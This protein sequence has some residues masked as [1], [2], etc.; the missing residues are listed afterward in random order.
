M[1]NHLLLM[2]LGCLSVALVS[3]T[4]AIAGKGKKGDTGDVKSADA[5]KG[6]VKQADAK[7]CEKEKAKLEALTL[8]G[9]LA[10]EEVE[11][12]TKDGGTIS[13]TV[14]YV[15]T[16]EEK[17]MVPAPRSK[18]KGEEP[19]IKLADFAGAKVTIIARGYKSKGKDG[20]ERTHVHQITDIRR[21]AAET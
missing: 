13:M 15:Q 1:K 18:K 21:I 7:K 3:V 10:S 16:G 19:V 14:Y 5:T 4:P 9:T 11:K 2:L 6:D 17:V 12:K 8:T 20:A